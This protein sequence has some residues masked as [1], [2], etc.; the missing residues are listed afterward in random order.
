MYNIFKS[1]KKKIKKWSIVLKI[2]DIVYVFKQKLKFEFIKIRDCEIF[3]RQEISLF[4]QEED[5]QR[6]F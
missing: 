3:I 4:E 2:Q 6:D 5:L 1:N